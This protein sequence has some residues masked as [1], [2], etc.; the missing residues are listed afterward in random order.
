VGAALSLAMAAG[1]SGPEPLRPSGP[2]D[3]VVEDAIVEWTSS[4]PGLGM[5]RYGRRRGTYDVV[6]Y[7]YAA[8]REDRRAVSLHRVPL[9]SAAAGDTLYLV[10]IDV[11]DDGRMSA[12]PEFRT[13][14]GPLPARPAPLRWTMIDVG[15]G[16]SHLLTMPGTGRRI[17]IDAGERRDAANVL[18]FLAAEGVHRLDAVVAT[19]IH[20]DHIGGLVGESWTTA[21]GVLGQMEVGAFLEGPGHSG[22]RSAHDELLATLSA[23]HVVPTAIEVGDTDASDPALA[24][25]PAVSVEVLNAGYGRAIGG[26]TESDWINN[27]SVVLRIAYGQVEWILGGDAEAPVQIRLIGSGHPLDSEV[28][29]V[30]HHGVADASEPAYLDAVRPRVGLIPITTDESMSG[31]LPSGTVL[32]RLRERRIDVYA[33]DRA[34]PL[35]IPARYGIGYNVTVVTDGSSY[36]VRV[37]PSSSRHWPPEAV[38][39]GSTRSAP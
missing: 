26:D 14:V 20:A 31:T 6:A 2:A 39:A 18:A 8:D 37:E 32:Q 15:F 35:G 9:L 28:L 27:D 24:W 11:A 23:R 33:S 19:H 1:C 34:E 17:L 10:A 29:K 25:D 16:D 12:A 5:V 7:P 36:E 38:A 22:Q 4:S 3:V 21:D 13:V 30:H